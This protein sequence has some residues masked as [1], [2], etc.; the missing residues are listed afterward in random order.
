MGHG[1]SLDGDVGGDVDEVVQ[2]FA[3]CVAE[4]PAGRRKLSGGVLVGSEGRDDE[5]EGDVGDG[6][7]QQQDVGDG[8]HAHAR[9][10]DD[11]DERVSGDAEQGDDG[12]EDGNDDGVQG[13]SVLGKDA[14]A[15]VACQWLFRVGCV[16]TN[17]MTI[18]CRRPHAHMHA[19]IHTRADW[20]VWQ[21]G[22]CQ[23]GRLVRRPGE[24]P[25]QT[26][27]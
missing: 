16:T 2:Q 21:P 11:D 26:L 14:A 22:T 24:P 5:H 27:K 3:H 10:Y 4:R 13:E 6:E 1:S 15:D 18:K 17:C 19:G 8:A 9:H 25:R 20:A 23:V 12:E 7:I